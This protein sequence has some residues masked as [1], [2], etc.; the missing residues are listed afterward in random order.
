MY[1]PYIM[2]KLKEWRRSPLVFVNDCIDVTP[3]SQQL[4]FLAHVAKHKR[5]TIR[6]G[7]GCHAKGTGIHMFPYGFKAVEDIKVGDKILGDD[8]TVRNVLTLYR[9]REEMARIKYHD[10][11]YYDVNMSHILSLVCT[12]SKSG[13]VSGKKYTTTVR[14]YLAMIEERPSLKGRFAGYKVSVDYPKVP[15]MIPPYILGLWLGN[16]NHRRIEIT[17]IDP[18]PI[19]AWID[20][21]EANGLKA[22]TTCEKLHKL[23]GND[24]NAV[25][26]A[27]KYYNLLGNKHIPVEYIYNSKEVRLQ[28]LAGLIDS[29]GYVDNR[30][31]STQFQIVQKRKEIAEGIHLIARSCGMHSTFSEKEK[32]W[33]CKGVKKWGT[34]YE[35]KIS[36]NTELIP[37]RIPKK[38]ASGDSIKR[39]SNLHFGFT[40]EKL[41][42]DYYYGFELDGNNLYVLSDFTVTHNTGK[43]ASVS[44][45][46]LWFLATRA[47]AKVACT[48]PTARQLSDILWSELSK[49]IRKSIF[50]DEFVIQKDKVFQK[51]NPKEW[52]CRAISVSARSSKEEQAETL[53]GLHGDHLLIVV[54]EASG[55]HDPVFIPLEGA[56]TQEDNKVV[57]ISNMTKNTGYFYE[58]HFHSQMKKSWYQLHWDSRKSTNVNPDYSNYMRMK[59]GEDSNVFRIRVAGDPP[60]QDENT[61][62]PLWAAQQCIG[63]EFEVAEDEPLFLGVDVARY[64]DDASVILPRKGLIIQPWEIFRK[65]NTI[66]LGG[67]VN[68]TYQELD[69]QGVAIDVIG[70]GAGV[71]DWLAKRNIVN[72]YE[73]NVTHASSNIEKF[74]RLRDE[75]WCR[76]RDNCILG[77]YS[78]PLLKAQG[79]TESY[80]EQ[81]ANELATV[82][83]TFNSQGG[84]IV[85]SKKDLKS[86]GIPSPNIADALGLTEYFANK[87]TRVFSK[88]KEE[89]DYIGRQGYS[90]SYNTMS[91][92]SWLGN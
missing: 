76:V 13:F 35:V 50:A 71:S 92:T 53:A 64:G 28:L 55:V 44:W 5:I 63:N 34:Y 21:A 23:S 68:Q 74:N 56:L 78:F 62:I 38:Q 4:D 60:L 42:E 58:T 54:D 39:R 65:L 31:N 18:G 3:S 83:Y 88:E 29:D 47:Y 49:W 89:S 40:V 70:V 36:R 25:V 91:S 26:A 12:E 77:K 57:L 84:Y 67:F 75:L 9:G 85:E 45:A 46:I 19:N 27:F 30:S 51:D 10:S 6:S 80:G 48:A 69:A 82:R 22:T 11:T 90:N 32:N 16:G 79:D 43:D 2:G 17:N 87:A 66:D 59:Y 8:G 15:V 73:V 86:R 7:H 33:T 20:F 81:L 41:E 14:E 24:K 52:W 72:L 1:S 37:T 61:L